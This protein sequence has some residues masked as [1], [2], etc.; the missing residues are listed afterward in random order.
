MQDGRFG[1]GHA[2]VG[3]FV[4]RCV[5]NPS[6]LSGRLRQNQLTAKTVSTLAT[7]LF[8]WGIRIFF[9]IT[10]SGEYA[11]TV[12]YVQFCTI[13][14]AWWHRCFGLVAV[15]ITTVSTFIGSSRY[16][17]AIRYTWFLH[18]E[19]SRVFDKISH[20]QDGTSVT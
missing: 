11:P 18:Y 20:F 4:L 13:V 9:I 17:T 7:R 12:F 19:N 1:S 16:I 6:D 2:Q 3:A 10:L 5:E 14:R 15:N 8:F